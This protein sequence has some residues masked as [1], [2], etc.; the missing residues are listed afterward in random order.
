M[1][2]AAVHGVHRR[3]IL[4]LTCQYPA[5]ATVPN[6]GGASGGAWGRTRAGRPTTREPRLGAGRADT[7]ALRGG[8]AAPYGPA[9]TSPWR[10]AGRI[11]GLATR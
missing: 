3:Y 11:P 9:P 1:P 5:S 4:A 7:M 6:P 2:K 10:N 8:Q